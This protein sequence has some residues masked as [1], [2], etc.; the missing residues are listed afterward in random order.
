MPTRI[1][2]RNLLAPPKQA[3]NPNS[4][5]DGPWNSY[6][7][8]RCLLTDVNTRVKGACGYDEKGLPSVERNH[9]HIVHSGDKKLRMKAKPFGQPLAVTF[10]KSRSEEQTQDAPRTIRESAKCK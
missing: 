8:V 7:G 3:S 10:V 4:V 9:S 1:I 5:D 6:R 2:Q